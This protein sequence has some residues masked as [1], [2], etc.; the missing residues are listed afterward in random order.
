M[1][2]SDLINLKLLPAVMMHQAVRRIGDLI[3]KTPSTPK[4]SEVF[5]KSTQTQRSLRLKCGKGSLVPCVIAV[6][7]LWSLT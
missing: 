3:I 4:T 2:Y 6:H 7:K 5:R 1:S